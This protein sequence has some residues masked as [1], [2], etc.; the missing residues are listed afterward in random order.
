M[1]VELWYPKATRLAKT[2]HLEIGS[3]RNDADRMMFNIDKTF[4]LRCIIKLKY[5]PDS[6]G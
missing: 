1:I 3:I 2:I 6:S 4:F 5:R